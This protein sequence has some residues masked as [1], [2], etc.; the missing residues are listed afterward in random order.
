[1]VTGRIGVSMAALSGVK[2]VTFSRARA[3][4]RL[5]EMQTA[6]YL[7][8]RPRCGAYL[9]RLLPSGPRNE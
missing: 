8:T 9:P 2:D 6:G 3:E 4:S 1:M 5:L 7:A